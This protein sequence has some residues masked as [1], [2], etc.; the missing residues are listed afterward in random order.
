MLPDYVI[1]N[2]GRD[3][4]VTIEAQTIAYRLGAAIDGQQAPIHLDTYH[5][6]AEFY[7]QYVL[8][9]GGD[10]FDAAEGVIGAMR[11]QSM[12]P[13][14]ESVFFNET[15][16]DF[17]ADLFENALGREGAEAGRDFWANQIDGG[18]MTREEVVIAF[19][20]S[21]EA[22]DALNPYQWLDVG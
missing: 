10:A 11:V 1:P 14:T 7:M 13:W 4:D 17:V 18:H 15:S 9:E 20:L 16:E 5:S 12:N 21:D 2:V 8:N 19:A 22:E 6:P 3:L